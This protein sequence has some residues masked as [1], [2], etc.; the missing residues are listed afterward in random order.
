MALQ[1]YEKGA[2][3]K[4]GA[5]LAETTDFNLEH[6]PQLQPIFTQQK[7]FSGMSPGAEVTRIS[8]NSAVPRVGFEIDYLTPLQG[9]VVV[10][11]TLFGHGQKTTCKGYITNV[12]QQYGVNQAASVS[13]DFIGEPVN[14]STL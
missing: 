11:M 14:A 1:A 2:L 7:G 6:D 10:E 13:F 12:K 4:D 9:V 3:F 5:L 8:V